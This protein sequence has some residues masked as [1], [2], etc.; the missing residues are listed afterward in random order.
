MTS[1]LEQLFEKMTTE[2]RQEVT[3]FAAFVIA[4]R[5]SQSLQVLTDEISSQEFMKLIA[6]SGSFNW[7]DRPEE[8]GY[9]LEDGEEV[10]WPEKS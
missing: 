1:Q 10:Q 4:R 9:S 2:E 5:N 8:N 3:F 7:L 6:E